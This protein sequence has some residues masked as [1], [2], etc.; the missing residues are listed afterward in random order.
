MAK[1]ADSQVR[2][3]CEADCAAL[4][5]LSGELG[6]PATPQGIAQRLAAIAGNRDHEVLVACT[7]DGSVAG[8]ADVSVQWL[9]SR[10]PYAV[11]HGLVVAEGQRSQGI[12]RRLL[13]AAEEW[14]R[15][16]GVTTLLVRSNVVRADAHRFYE[17]EG[18]GRKKTSAVFEKALKK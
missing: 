9:L 1:I 15:E 16:Q 5:S 4:A 13:A 12:G 14:A 8:W 17:R 11:L 3:A 6:Y 2:A 7:G 10:D 18:Y